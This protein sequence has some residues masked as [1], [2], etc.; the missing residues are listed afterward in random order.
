MGQMSRKERFRFAVGGI[1]QQEML[2]RLV[3]EDTPL[4]RVVVTAYK[5]SQIQKYLKGKKR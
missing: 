3:I 4:E 1:V 2:L 5:T